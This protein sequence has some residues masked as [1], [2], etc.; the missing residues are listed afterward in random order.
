MTGH[1]LNRLGLHPEPWT[2][3]DKFPFDSP[4]LTESPLVTFKLTL[5]SRTHR[6]PY[7][8]TPQPYETSYKQN[9]LVKISPN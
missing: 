8:P 6:G 2:S 5:L 4:L 1:L 3:P 9:H 7:V